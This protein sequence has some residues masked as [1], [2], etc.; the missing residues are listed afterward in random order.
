[1][2]TKYYRKGTSY[3]TIVVAC[4]NLTVTSRGYYKQAHTPPS[5]NSE[6]VNVKPSKSV[7]LS[8]RTNSFSI[9]VRTGFS[10]M[11][12]ESKLLKSRFDLCVLDMQ[13][14]NQPHFTAQWYDC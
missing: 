6:L 12:S 8:E 1:M 10:D 14:L 3:H 7:W 2:H 4:A 11:K 9:G 5:L 13:A